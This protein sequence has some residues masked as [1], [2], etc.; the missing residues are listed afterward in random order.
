MTH[1]YDL[2]LRYADTDALGHVNNALYATYAEAARIAFFREIGVA[3]ENLILARLEIDY[4]RQ[5]RFGESPSVES[6]VTKIG[7]TSIGVAHRLLVDGE[8]AAEMRT[9]VVHFDYEAN[10]PSGVPQEA[11]ELLGPYVR[12]VDPRR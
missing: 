8:V 11:R 4:R 7:N 2:Q 12:A 5:V 6:F 9:V 1:T 3:V 10:A